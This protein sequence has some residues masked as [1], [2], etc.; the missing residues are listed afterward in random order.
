MAALNK[1]GGA[2]G[3]GRTDI[4]ENRYVGMKS[5]GAYETPGGT[6][7]QKAHR[8]IESITLDREVAHLKDELMPRYASLIY[9]GYWYSP[10]RRMMQ[11]MIDASQENVNG[12]VRLK[13]YKGNVM[14][15][16]RKSDSD[17]LFDPT[18]ATFEEDRGAYNQKD[19]EGFIRLNALRLRIAARRK[20]KK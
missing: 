16:G 7:M 14:V 12:V 2:N 9:N 18:I 11:Q 17:S 3:V 8:A 1:V 6:I 4:V 15:V 19:A 20:R 5:R 10:E 13:L